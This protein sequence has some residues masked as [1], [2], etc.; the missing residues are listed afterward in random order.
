[1]LMNI[2]G[3]IHNIWQELKISSY[4]WHKNPSFRRG[5]MM[6]LSKIQNSRKLD[7]I[8]TTC[9]RFLST[10]KPSR[11]ISKVEMRVHDGACSLSK[12]CSFSG[13]KDTLRNFTWCSFNTDPMKM[14]LTIEEKGRL[15][16]FYYCYQF[17]QSWHYKAHK[18][19]FLLCFNKKIKIT[20]P[21]N[22]YSNGKLNWMINL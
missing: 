21:I 14:P 8:Q 2:S 10:T 18:F 7:H 6:M 13:M 20:K 3:K 22:I 9:Q 1:M 17:I 12:F 15:V 16:M 11:A 5:K 4:I 19:V